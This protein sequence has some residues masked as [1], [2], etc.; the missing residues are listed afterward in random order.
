[1]C[2]AAG[3]RSTLSNSENEVRTWNAKLYIASFTICCSQRAR[4]DIGIAV[5]S[6]EGLIMP[7]LPDVVGRTLAK[8]G[9]DWQALRDEAKSRW[10]K[11]SDYSGAT[12]YTSP[13]S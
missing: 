1:M 6:P 11:P 5:D 9:A 13:I 7:V 3:L 12:F 4:I 8:L 10:L 2:C